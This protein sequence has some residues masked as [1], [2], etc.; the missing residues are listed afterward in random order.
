MGNPQITNHVCA[1]SLTGF[2]NKTY[3]KKK[4]VKKF[5]GTVHM[6]MYVYI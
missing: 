6:C 3:T 5:K 4:F 2:P 1:H